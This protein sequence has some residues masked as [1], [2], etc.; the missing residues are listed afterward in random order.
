MLGTYTLSSGYYDAYYKKALKTRSLIKKDFEEAFEK[1]D[2]ILGPVS[3]IL[4]FKIGEKAGDPLSMYLA[5]IYTTPV[6]LAG[7]P[8]ISIP[9]EL[10]K[11]GLP[12]GLHII[13]S[14]FRE[15]KLFN[16]ANLIQCKI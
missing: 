8:A 11:T 13:T 4:P 2:A 10:S 6:N 16:I 5:D 1:V 12:I 9:L 14:H 7:L 3:P 15:E